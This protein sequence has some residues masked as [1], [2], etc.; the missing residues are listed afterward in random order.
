MAGSLAIVLFAM[1]AAS[2]ILSPIL[3]A[4]VVAVCVTPLLRWL[5]SKGVPGWLALLLVLV[6][7]LGVLVA[8]ISYVGLSISRLT[9]ALP[10]YIE[11]GQETQESLAA[12]KE[13]VESLLASKGIDVETLISPDLFQPEKLVEVLGVFLAGLASFLGDMVWMVLILIFVLMESLGVPARIRTKIHLEDHPI[14]TRASQLNQEV[15][16]Y[17]WITTLTG[18]LAGLG[19]TVLLLIIGVDFPIMWGILAWLASYIPS[20]GFWIALIPPA[21]LALLQFGWQQALIVVVGYIL[22]NGAVENGLKPRIL[23]RGLNLSPL[24]TIL[25]LFLWAWVLGPTGAI[26][27]VPLTMAVMKLFMESSAGTGWLLALMG[28]AGEA[29]DSPQ[30]SAAD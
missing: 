9:E 1:R 14:L 16:Q 21:I 6:V 13:T 15:R 12:G 24:V 23:E 20:V 28:G 7:L 8:V 4:L 26:L 10:T 5:Q 30:P 18:M 3:L 2:D 11:A 17:M 27:A 25:S 22:I 19:D 29:S